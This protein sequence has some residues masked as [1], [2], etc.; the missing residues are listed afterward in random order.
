MY[1]VETDW[2]L[3]ALCQ[4]KTKEKLVTP[5]DAGYISLSEDLEYF[6]SDGIDNTAIN[7][8]QTVGN[9]FYQ[10]FV[11]NGAKYHRLYRNKYDEHHRNRAINDK[12]VVVSLG[13]GSVRT[14]RTS[15]D[16]AN[17]IPKCF[18]CN[19]SDDLSNLHK[20]ETMKSKGGSTISF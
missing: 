4:R 3:C 1:E 19:L 13:N 10:T 8:L 17:Y 11:Q 20:V 18:F 9:S 5:K 15:F 2:S 12:N 14:T 16:S 6:L 7:R